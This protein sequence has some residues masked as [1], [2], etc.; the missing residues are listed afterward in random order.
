MRVQKM[1]ASDVKKKKKYGK[2][3]KSVFKD[4]NFV[5]IYHYNSNLTVFDK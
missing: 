3:N 1:H 4:Q 5:F 2:T